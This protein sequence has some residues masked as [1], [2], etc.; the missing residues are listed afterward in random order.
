MTKWEYMFVRH[1]DNR[2]MAI[3]YPGSSSYEELGVGHQPEWEDWVTKQGLEGWE[4]A[5]ERTL[6]KSI[7]A[8]ATLKRQI[9]E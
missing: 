1:F 3:K 6:N 7:S 2:I 5:S 4:L 9:P 8:H